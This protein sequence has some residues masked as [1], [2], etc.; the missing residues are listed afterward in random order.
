MPTPSED[1]ELLSRP[2]DGPDAVAIYEGHRQ[3]LVALDR[4][5][6]FAGRIH[7]TMPLTWEN[8]DHTRVSLYRLIAP[9]LLRRVP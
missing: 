9:E 4:L 1:L 6:P 3:R 7:V 8:W 5:A 2:I